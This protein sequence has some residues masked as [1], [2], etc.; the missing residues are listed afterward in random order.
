MK[1]S[2]P[3]RAKRHLYLHVAMDILPR[4][5]RRTWH[6]HCNLD[7]WDWRLMYIGKE[8]LICEYACVHMC[9]CVC[10]C[11]CAYVYECA[12]MYV[13]GYV[14]VYVMYGALC[15]YEYVEGKYH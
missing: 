3:K 11:V 9:M 14:H 15:Q 8:L 2:F 5:G 1:S 7:F 13:Y 6:C 12:C 10:I 4:H